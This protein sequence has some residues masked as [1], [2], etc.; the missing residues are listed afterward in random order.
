MGFFTG[1][2]A[3]YTGNRHGSFGTMKAASGNT[4]KAPKSGGT[5]GGAK[6]NAAKAPMGRSNMK[7]KAPPA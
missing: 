6:G 2:M 4:P 1:S 3:E 7:L 5:I